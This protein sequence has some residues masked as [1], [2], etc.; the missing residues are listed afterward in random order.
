MANSSPPKRAGMSEWRRCVWKTPA[1]PLQ[2]GVA[3]EVAVRV[4]DLAQQVEVGHDHRQRRARAL[5]PVELLAERA[6]EVARVEEARLRVDARLLLER[7]DAQRAVDEEERRDAI[8]RSSGFQSQSPARA[9]PSMASTKSVERLST[10]KSPVPRNECPRARWS[11]VASRTWFSETKTTD[12]DEARERELE[13]RAEAGVAD[14]LDRPPRRQ[15]VQRVV[16]DVERLDVPGVA[17]L[18]PLGD[19]V[20]DAEERDQ[21]RRQQEHPGDEE[22]DRR[23]VALVARR[24]DDEELGHRRAGGEDE[25][26]EPAVGVEREVRERN[27]AAATTASA[28]MA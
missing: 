16:G 8:G 2:D 18:Q 1:M 25:E 11:I 23:V 6:G 22:D 21:L 3:G 14:E 12:G 10:E 7:R 13:L 26:R 24:P 28:P 27:A 15:A 19:P 5:R 17:H 20:D 4:V 9:T